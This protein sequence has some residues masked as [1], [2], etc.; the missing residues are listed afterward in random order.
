MCNSPCNGHCHL[1]QVGQLVSSPLG[2]EGIVLGVKLSATG[3]G[4]ELWVRWKGGVEAPADTAGGVVAAPGTEQ[5]RRD[6]N[7][8]KCEAAMLATKW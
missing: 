8:R 6:I 2:V 3:T 1:E 7:A 4:S 5:L